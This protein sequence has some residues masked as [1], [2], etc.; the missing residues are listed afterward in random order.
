VEM[1]TWNFVD[2]ADW[3]TNGP[4]DS[5]PDKA[6][7]VDE[8]TGLDCLIHRGPHGALCGYVGVPET[9]ALFGSDYEVADV[10]V[11]GGLTFADRCHGDENGR[12]ICHPHDTAANKTVWWLGF[13]C[14]HSG[15]FSPAYQRENFHQYSTYKSF[16]YVKQ[17]VE[18][19]AEQLSSPQPAVT[20]PETNLHKG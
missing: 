7:W 1:Q 19:L 12:G 8:S 9:H 16:D 10:S 2:K 4:W 5:E 14:A 3:P 20:Q 17:E 18:S 11:H 6:H 13:D 15:D